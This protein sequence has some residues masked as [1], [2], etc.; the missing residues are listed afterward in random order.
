M[1]TDLHLIAKGLNGFAHPLRI[2]ALV[3]LERDSRTLGRPAAL[4]RRSLAGP[5]SSPTTTIN[6]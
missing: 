2:K 1:T 3:L 5:P 6:A 4:L